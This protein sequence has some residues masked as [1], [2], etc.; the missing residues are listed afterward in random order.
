MTKYALLLMGVY[1]FD[2][3]E[4]IQLYKRGWRLL[5]ILS[6]LR[7]TTELAVLCGD[8]ETPSL[9]V[10]KK[11]LCKNTVLQVK[12]YSR[13]TEYQRYESTMGNCRLLNCDHALVVT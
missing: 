2:K 11:P 10:K 4:E 1:A 9:S 13:V 3:G 7:N 8:E 5:L 6:L 12:V